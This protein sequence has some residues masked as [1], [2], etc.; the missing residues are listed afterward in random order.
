M[1]R[2][3]MPAVGSQHHKR[4]GARPELGVGLEELVRGH[5][6]GCRRGGLAVQSRLQPLA[7]ARQ[8]PMVSQLRKAETLV[9]KAREAEAAAQDQGVH[10][11]AAVW[12]HLQRRHNTSPLRHTGDDERAGQQQYDLDKRRGQGHCNVDGQVKKGGY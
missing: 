4:S 3:Q 9:A 10:T 2:L 8:P 7:V 11:R 1:G 12:R 5:E 6:S